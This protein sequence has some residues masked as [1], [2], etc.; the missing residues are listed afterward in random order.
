MAIFAYTNYP[1]T[2]IRLNAMSKKFT[3]LLR[4][5]LRLEG[6]YLTGATSRSLV[7]ENSFQ[8][9]VFYMGLMTTPAAAVL[10]EGRRAGAKVPYNVILD[11]VQKRGLPRTGYG[12]TT[13]AKNIAEQ[14]HKI[15]LK[16]MAS[17]EKYGSPTP[18]SFA[19]S[20][21]GERKGFIS[22]TLGA[23]MI[24]KELDLRSM[25]V[26]FLDIHTWNTLAAEINRANGNYNLNF[27]KT[28]LRTN[29]PPNSAYKK[30]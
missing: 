12:R 23:G 22:R 2:A 14:Q 20:K 21:N 5:E 10:D 8:G 26:E 27:S 3:V 11:W 4:R 30:R 9:D 7:W 19:F 25:V 6:H 13:R 18:N 24:E 28:L 16:V 1:K 15:T 29:I 17:I